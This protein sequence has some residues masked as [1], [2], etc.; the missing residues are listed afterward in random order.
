MASGSHRAIYA[1]I[2]GNLAIAITKFVAAFM[3]GSSAMM[4]EGIH[5][6][7]DTGNGGLLLLGIRQSKRPPDRLHPF[8]HGKDLYFYVLIVGISIFA[9]GG[10]ISIYEGILHTL[11]P[12]PMTGVT[13]NYIVLGV[14][15][16]FEAIVWTIAFKE[17]MALKGE[18]E[19]V[20]QNIRTS[21]DPTTFAVLFEDTAAL[22]GLLVALMG[23]FLAHQFNIPALDGVA[24][25]TIGVILCSVAGFLIYESKGL[26][27]GESANPEV[28][29]SVEQ[30]ALS[31]TSVQK[32][33]RVLTMHMGPRQVILNLD[34][35]FNPALSADT[36]ETA[37]ERLEKE[38]RAQHKEI[39]YI[40]IEAS[41][42]AKH[43]REHQQQ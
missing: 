15:V 3:S 39:K 13:L 16:V 37:V 26:L 17:F 43:H 19:S 22:A 5:S 4:A 24:S 10:G 6:L 36:I 1:A 25:I 31:D 29:N 35:K 12:E 8:G 7:V 34:V 23:I 40:F 18:Q 27:L 11:H 30:I 41:T 20:L 32:V 33:N 28:V 42:L 9:V 14:A 21:K 38:I 2:L